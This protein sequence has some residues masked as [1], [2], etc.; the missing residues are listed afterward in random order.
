MLLFIG[1]AGLLYYLV[2]RESDCAP[3]G[4]GGE[5][6]PVTISPSNFESEV[7]T[8]ALSPSSRISGR[9]GE[10]PAKV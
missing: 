3:L 7:I 5:G 6:A 2:P 10:A 8:R 1:L 9:P 4:I